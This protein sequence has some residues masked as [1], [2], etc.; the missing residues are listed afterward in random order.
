M[1]LVP[2]SNWSHGEV[3]THWHS[4]WLHVVVPDPRAT[5]SSVTSLRV[6]HEGPEANTSNHQASLYSVLYQTLH[7]NRLTNLPMSRNPVGWRNKALQCV[8]GLERFEMC[9]HKHSPLCH[10]QY[11]TFGAVAPSDHLPLDMPSCG[12]HPELSALWLQPVRGL[13]PKRLSTIL[14]Q[15]STRAHPTLQ[16]IHTVPPRNR[17]S[18][19]SNPIHLFP[20][21]ETCTCAPHVLRMCLCCAQTCGHCVYVH[22]YA[23]SAAPPNPKGRTHIFC[24]FANPASPS[25]SGSEARGLETT[26]TISICLLLSC[27]CEGPCNAKTPRAAT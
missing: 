8:S 26:R 5:T 14:S 23:V 21:C 27:L 3:P 4:Q 2:L 24:T 18:R 13:A 20:R 25:L 11:P 19:N 6:S 17:S 12:Q 22:F 7:Y 1:F 10:M 9:N 15:K 16:H